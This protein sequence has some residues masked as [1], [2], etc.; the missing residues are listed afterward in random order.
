MRRVMGAE[1][2]GKRAASVTGE[3]RIHMKKFALIAATLVM[4]AGCA[5]NDSGDL[6]SDAGDPAATDTTTATGS[7]A[8]SQTGTG[9]TPDM[10]SGQN[11]VPGAATIQSEL[12]IESSRVETNSVEQT[13]SQPIQAQPD[14]GQQAQPQPPTP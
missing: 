10:S 14:Q 11:N 12:Q 9:A 2:F 6:S 1:A 4:F 8:T 3:K 5:R 7:P 13:Q